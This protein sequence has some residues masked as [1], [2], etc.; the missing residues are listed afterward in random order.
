[1]EDT[2]RISH[3]YS[4]SPLPSF[5][6]LLSLFSPFSSTFSRTPL[7]FL[8]SPFFSLHFPLFAHL[9]LLTFSPQISIEYALKIRNELNYLDG[10][11]VRE[12]L[13]SLL[14]P[15]SSLLSFVLFSSLLFPLSSLLFSSLLFSSLLSSPHLSPARVG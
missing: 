11:L 3:R 8:P 7:Y 15:L 14:S 2:F 1:M 6:S 13:S 12:N 9:F 10:T 5:F 4:F